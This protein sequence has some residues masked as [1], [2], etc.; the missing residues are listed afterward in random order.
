MLLAQYPYGVAVD[1]AGNVYV[2][3]SSN[4]RIRLVSPSGATSTLAGSGTGAF[5]DGVGEA[6]SLN[7]R[8]I[9]F[10]SRAFYFI[11]A[12]FEF[13]CAQINACL[14]PPHAKFCSPRR[15]HEAWP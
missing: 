13:K 1:A 12:T 15:T 6:A 2:A 11:V 3:D 10:C 5:A 9:C 7:V 8:C 4:H 14:C